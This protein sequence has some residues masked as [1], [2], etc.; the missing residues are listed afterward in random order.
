MRK[1]AIKAFCYFVM[2]YHCKEAICSKRNK[3][4]ASCVIAQYFIQKLTENENDD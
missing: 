4:D 1:K 2:E 3:C